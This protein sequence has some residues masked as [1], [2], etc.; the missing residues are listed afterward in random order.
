MKESW[1]WK[2]V[3]CYLEIK[4]KFSCFRASKLLCS[5]SPINVGPSDNTPKHEEKQI[6]SSVL[7]RHSWCLDSKPR[8]QTMWSAAKLLRKEETPSQ[9]IQ[10]RDIRKQTCN[11][12]KQNQQNTNEITNT[13]LV[14][15]CFS[16][17]DD[18]SIPR[19]VLSF[20]SQS[21]RILVSNGLWEV[22]L[23]FQKSFHSKQPWKVTHCFSLCTNPL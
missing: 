23:C 19:W 13:K 2:S 17:Y 6:S 21:K 5:N 18:H 16:S 8:Q 11:Q 7:F 20:V 3:T 14:F 4:L 15:Y 1:N 9:F 22:I 12:T 10:A